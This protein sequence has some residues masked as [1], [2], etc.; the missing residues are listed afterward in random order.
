[1]GDKDFSKDKSQEKKKVIFK[2]V[3][4]KIYDLLLKAKNVKIVAL[5]GTP[6]INYPNEIA[7]TINLLKGVQTVYKLEYKS[8]FDDLSIFKKLNYIDNIQFKYSEKNK[9]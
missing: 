1:M 9:Y 2:T 6:I 5:S 4:K 3:S 7:Y 8:N